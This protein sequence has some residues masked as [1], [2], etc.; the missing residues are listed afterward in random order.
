LRP[1]KALLGRHPV[2]LHGLRVVLRD[3]LKS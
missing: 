3:A 2:P 1:G